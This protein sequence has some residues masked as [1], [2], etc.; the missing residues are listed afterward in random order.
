MRQEVGDHKGEVIQRKTRRTTQRTDNGAL[1]LGGFPRELVRAA[2]VVLAV[3]RAT[4]TPLAD[5]LGRE[6]PYATCGWSRSRDPIRPLRRASL[7]RP[8]SGGPARPWA[9]WSG[10]S[11][12]ARRGW[13]GLSDGASA[14]GPPR[15]RGLGTTVKAPSVCLNRPTNLIP[16]TF[17]YQTPN[18][19]TSHTG[20]L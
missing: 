3:G 6:T 11:R 8:N 13:C 9:R 12:P 17:R 10:R 20:R 19:T 2:R 18:L 1:L 7:A 4:L 5:G 15:L 14:S 16:R